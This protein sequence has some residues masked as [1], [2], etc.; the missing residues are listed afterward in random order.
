MYVSL[1]SLV[2]VWIGPHCSEMLNCLQASS[3]IYL[4]VQQNPTNHKRTE[5]DE[6][7]FGKNPWSINGRIPAKSFTGDL[8]S[9]S[10]LFPE[11]FKSWIPHRRNTGKSWR[12]KFV[13]NFD[14]LIFPFCNSVYIFIFIAKWNIIS[15][16]K[17]IE[18]LSQLKSEV[19]HHTSSIAI[20]I[21]LS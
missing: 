11:I 10:F 13:Q 12:G 5:Y 16:H 20:I 14:L 7:K 6:D 3:T 18:Q 2:Y 4:S 19:L 1:R 15:D 8:C 9:E 17:T 21:I